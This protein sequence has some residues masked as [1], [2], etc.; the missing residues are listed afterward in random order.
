M[1][2]Y[3]KT[4]M[5]TGLLYIIVF[6]AGILSIVYVI[7]KPDYLIMVSENA[8]QVFLGAFFQLVMVP[9]YI[10]IALLLYPIL[11][12]YNERLSLGFV[13]FRFIAGAFHILGII[14]LPLFLILSR[15]FV[16]AGAPDLSY[17]HTLGNLLRTGRDLLNHV[18]MIISLS[19]GGLMLY[20]V[21]YRSKL[22]PRWLSGW[23][24]VGT[25]LTILASL[26]FMFRL[27]DL[28]TPFYLII[29]LPLAVQEI[30]FALWLIFKGFN[31][32]IVDSDLHEM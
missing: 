23:G 30:V 18:G 11:K 19:I 1:N 22:V 29:N 32:V 3:R 13:G 6:A 24:L 31:P 26:L 28:V 20:S 10:G 8:N 5:Y 27:I 9:A 16:K 15:E 17:F 21:L 12:Q 2:T 25:A 4:A 14:S 7:E